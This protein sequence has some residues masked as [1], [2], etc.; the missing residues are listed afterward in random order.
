MSAKHALRQSQLLTTYGPGALLDLPE[1]AVIVGGLDQWRY[2]DTHSGFVEE[3]RLVAK[4]QSMLQRQNLQLRL[5]PE[6]QDGYKSTQKVTAFEFPNWFVSQKTETSGAGVRRRRLLHRGALEKGHYRDDQKKKV[7]VVPIRFVRACPA[8]HIGDI[9]W[10]AFVHGA[11]DSTCMRDL[12]I[13]EHGTTGDLSQ[14]LVKCDCG[15]SENIGAAYRTESAKLGFC[16]GA[17]PWLGSF[18]REECREKNRLLLRSASNAYFSR[19]VS[20][21]SIPD[22]A[23]SLNTLVSALWAEGLQ[24]VPNSMPLALARQIP[25]LGK[26]LESYADA[27]L[28]A[29]IARHRGGTSPQR[30][31]KEAEF[32]A[33]SSAPADQQIEVPEGEFFARQLALAA[34]SSNAGIEK[35]VLVHRLREVMAQVGFTRF[36][37]DGTNI[38]GELEEN[39]RTAQLATDVHWLPAVVNRGEGVFLQLSGVAVQAWLQRPEVVIRGEE[40][41][42]GFLR[43][44]E[45]HPSSQRVF[46][47]LPYILLHTL[48]HMLMQAIA[49]DCGYPATS[50]RERIYAEDG[51]FGLLILTAA[52]DAQG[53][54]GGLVQAA[55][56]IDKYLVSALRAAELCSNDP[57]CS[58]HNPVANDHLV[59]AACHGCLLAP[60]TSCEQRNDFLDRA[61]VVSTID[62]LGAEFFARGQ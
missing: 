44:R 11:R 49:L 50:L 7:Q 47:G 55:R 6:A 35:I 60:E 17:R 23:D 3:P 4:L 31:I 22:T 15:A 10:K 18:A 2:A 24:L 33:L 57:V 52:A 1:T 38:H 32:D 19:T 59:G 56:E 46:P 30:S 51:K 36:Q 5:P 54:L 8:G 42:A 41:R 34:L 9:D 21:I 45:S 43:W 62:Q 39:I 20:V 14:T 13:E 29:A 53:S 16:D 25:S 12:W 37:P 40:L 48:S 28:L 61:L 27:P 26:Q 58:Q